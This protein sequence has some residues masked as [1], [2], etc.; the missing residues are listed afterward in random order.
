MGVRSG[1]K[2]PE[3]LKDGDVVEVGIDGIGSISNRIS[4]VRD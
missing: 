1:R 2:P 4:F 3:Y